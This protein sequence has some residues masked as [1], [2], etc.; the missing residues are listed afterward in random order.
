MEAQ[1][2]TEFQGRI[3]EDTI[4]RRR[5]RL[6]LAALRWFILSAVDGK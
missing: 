1:Y 6:S 4:R 2:T 5:Q 3:E